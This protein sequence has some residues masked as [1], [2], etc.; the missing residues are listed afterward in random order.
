MTK[1]CFKCAFWDQ[2]EGC[3]EHPDADSSKSDLGL[4]YDFKRDTCQS[5]KP[6]KR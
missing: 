6:R 3:C 1:I 2:V 5:F 4:G